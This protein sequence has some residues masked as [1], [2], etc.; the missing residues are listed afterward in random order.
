M[1]VSGGAG[2]PSDTPNGPRSRAHCPLARDAGLWWSQ[3]VVVAALLLSRV[4]RVG[5]AGMDEAERDVGGAACDLLL[6][7][8]LCEVVPSNGDAGFHLLLCFKLP[9]LC[10]GV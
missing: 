3:I 9:I 7:L 8:A 1:A 6:S 4:L 2:R 10:V 5:R